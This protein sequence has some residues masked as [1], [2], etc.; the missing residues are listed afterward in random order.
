M[1]EVSI[2]DLEIVSGGLVP[3]ANVYPGM[4]ARIALRTFPG[5]GYVAT[6]F[7]AGYAAGQWLNE[8]TPIQE[9]ISNALPDPAGT[10][11][12]EAG[13]NYN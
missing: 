3:P 13:T 5:L 10:S 9:W 8:N 11:Y 2:N 6:A 1:K 4:D 7:G 12:N